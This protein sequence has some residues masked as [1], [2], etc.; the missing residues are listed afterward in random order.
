[1]GYGDPTGCSDLM[2]CGGAYT[3]AIKSWSAER[4]PTDADR[5]EVW[6][7]HRPARR[8]NLR[9][10]RLLGCLHKALLW[11]S[12][13]RATLCSWNHRCTSNSC[14]ISREPVGSTTACAFPNLLWRPHGLL[15]PTSCGD[16]MGCGNPNS[17]IPIDVAMSWVA[18]TPWAVAVHE[19]GQAMGSAGPFTAA[20]RWAPA[21]RPHGIRRPHGLRPHLALSRPQSLRWPLGRATPSA[22][23]IPWAAAHLSAPTSDALRRAHGLRQVWRPQWLRRFHGLRRP[24]KLWR[25][26]RSPRRVLIRGVDPMPIRE[27][28]GVNTSRI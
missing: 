4:G 11:R 13:G 26:H 9:T 16:R 10:G 12:H 18:A 8:T 5:G 17:G 14:V 15:D 7:L 21:A 2:G 22:P 6:H 23:A 3:G 25:S 24:H 28:P 20:T 1:M 19:A 27:R